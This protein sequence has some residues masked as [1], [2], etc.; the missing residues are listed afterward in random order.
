MWQCFE[1]TGWDKLGRMRIWHAILILGNFERSS[2]EWVRCALKIFEYWQ[3]LQILWFL[4][5]LKIHNFETILS[6]WV[7]FDPAPPSKC[8]L[9]PGKLS[10]PLP[11]IGGWRGSALFKNFAEGR[12]RK[13]ISVGGGGMTTKKGPKWISTSISK[14]RMAKN[15]LEEFFAVFAEFQHDN[16]VFGQPWSGLEMV[17][18]GR[19]FKCGGGGQVINAG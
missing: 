13:K 19:A 2:V 14:Y 10:P 11:T 1:W 5:F 18:E 8:T 15:V 3:I 16:Y 4:V 6:K 17:G 9:T 12:V 7:K